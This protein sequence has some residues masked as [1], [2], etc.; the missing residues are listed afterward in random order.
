MTIPVAVVMGSQSDWD[1]MKEACDALS[2]FGVGW[3]AEVVSAHRTPKRLV[4]FAETAVDEGYK[5]IIAGAGGAAHL[6]GMIA[7]MT[8]LPVL[9]VPVKSRALSGLDSLLSIVQM[10]KGVAVGTLAIGTSGAW[11]AGL[12]AAQMLGTQDDA[13]L[14]RIADWKASRADEVL[15][16]ASL[17]QEPSQ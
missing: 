15:A 6:P 9:G 7:S 3:K 17:G 4:E 10:P 14:K 5:V 13:L 16:D 11:N 12:L 2:Q 1:T 8:P